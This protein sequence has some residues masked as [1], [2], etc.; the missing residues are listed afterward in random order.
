MREEELELQE[1]DSKSLPRR[2]ASH[3]EEFGVVGILPLAST[4]FE[5]ARVSQNESLRLV[6]SCH[7]FTSSELIT[8]TGSPSWLVLQS[9]QT[10]FFVNLPSS[11]LPFPKRAP[12]RKAPQKVMIDM[13]RRYL[14]RWMLVPLELS[15]CICLL[16]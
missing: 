5:D 15:D 9:S 4:S 12:E 11:I 7:Q 1:C 2:A 13:V 6:Q 10:P 16:R 3:S 8:A 14:L